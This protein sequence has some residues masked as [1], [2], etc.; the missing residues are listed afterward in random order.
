MA[1]NAFAIFDGF[2]QKAPPMRA[3]MELVNNVMTAITQAG[4]AVNVPEGGNSEAVT[5]AL[6]LSFVQA[7][8]QAW[9]HF[10]S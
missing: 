6:Q 10:P 7:L 4:H 1:F 2:G 9:H 3:A 8:P 5:L